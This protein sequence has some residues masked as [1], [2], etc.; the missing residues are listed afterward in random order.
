[1]NREK[2]FQRGIS[3]TDFVLEI[4]PYI[5]PL[6]PKRDG[7]NVISNDVFSYDELIVKATGDDNLDKEA[8]S[9]IE[10]VDHVGEPTKIF[11]SNSEL[12][13]KIDYVISSHNLEHIPNP[14]KFLNTCEK[15]LKDE[16]LLILALPDYR[17]CW[18]RFRSLTCSGDWLQAFYEER[19]KPTATQ[20]FI[21]NSMHC[22]WND[23]GILRPTMPM[24][25]ETKDLIPLET[26]ENAYDNFVSNFNKGDSLE[27]IDTHCWTFTPASFSL[28]L[29]DLFFLKLTKFSIR[30][31]ESR[32][33]SEFLVKLGKNKSKEMEKNEFFRQRK[34][35]FYRIASFYSDQI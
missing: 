28:M 31:V 4:G 26:L 15:V 20:I 24:D 29:L 9:R 5:N 11:N 3:K 16:G 21:Q 14:I 1:M 23:N 8:I 18:D 30:E 17:C 2:F 7:W 32:N 33:S 10:F 25:T 12:D 19:T 13:E 34:Q 6:F 35:L 22:R 27:Y